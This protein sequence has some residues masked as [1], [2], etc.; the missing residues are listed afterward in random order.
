MARL[1]YL[2]VFMKPIK[3]LVH[4]IGSF[5]RG[6]HA[7]VRSLKYGA[8]SIRDF[9]NSPRDE[10][11]KDFYQEAWME[12]YFLDRQLRD[13]VN[14]LP[15]LTEDRKASLLKAENLQQWTLESDV[16]DAL[17]THFDPE[18]DFQ[19]FVLLAK[20]VKNKATHVDR[21]QMVSSLR[22]DRHVPIASIIRARARQIHPSST[23]KERFGFRKKDKDGE[24]CLKDLRSWIK[25][26]MCLS[27]IARREPVLREAPN[28]IPNWSSS[29]AV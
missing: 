6:L 4:T 12:T 7:M 23:A 1:G 22:P 28:A 24:T 2:C 3:G 26:L 17:R 10:G 8:D 11:L 21:R 5:I 9:S 13:T 18:T 19:A 25:N 16:A 15:V 29:P 27:E 14:A 20:L